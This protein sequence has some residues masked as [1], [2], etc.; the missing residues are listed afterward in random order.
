MEEERIYLSPKGNKY[1]EDI[2][3][4]EFIMESNFS[5]CN[6]EDLLFFQKVHDKYWQS[7]SNS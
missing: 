5:H 3:V 7:Q 4:N 2:V 1:S 6:A